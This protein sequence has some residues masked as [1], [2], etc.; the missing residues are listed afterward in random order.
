MEYVSC[1]SMES[2]SLMSNPTSKAKTEKGCSSLIVSPEI[3]LHYNSHVGHQDGSVTK[4]D[5]L[6]SV[7][8]TNM[9]ARE[10]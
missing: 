2:P 4:P 1:R 7:P 3:K 5:Y 6:S 10:K 8:R 9:V